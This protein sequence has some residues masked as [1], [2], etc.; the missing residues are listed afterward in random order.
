MF[1]TQCGTAGRATGPS[2]FLLWGVGGIVTCWP[3]G[4]E[5]LQRL[6]GDAVLKWQF[7]LE[8][9]V[10]VQAFEKVRI[11]CQVNGSGVF[12]PVE[13][14]RDLSQCQGWVAEA[15][16]CLA[17]WFPG[18][19]CARG[20]VWVLGQG[21]GVSLRSHPGPAG[22]LHFTPFYRASFCLY[23]PCRW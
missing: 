1:T 15:L 2:S 17:L 18:V 20:R 19:F 21:A 16:R 23:T 11:S 4:D 10:Q 7:I 6:F 5:P 8:T 3:G 9:E 12:W 13:Q 22:G 14:S